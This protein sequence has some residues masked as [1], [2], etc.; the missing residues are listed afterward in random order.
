MNADGEF[1][2]NFCAERGV[3]LQ[4]ACFEH[5]FTDIIRRTGRGQNKQ[6]TLINFVVLHERIMKEVLDAKVVNGILLK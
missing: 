5:Q 4:N 6:K 2:V 1:L 3:F